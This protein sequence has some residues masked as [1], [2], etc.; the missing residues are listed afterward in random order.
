MVEEA[1]LRGFEYIYQLRTELKKV[2]SMANQALI[3][4]SPQLIRSVLQAGGAA[5]INITNLLGTDYLPSSSAKDDEILYFKSNRIVGSVDL[6]FD[7]DSTPRLISMGISSTSA[8]LDIYDNR[9]GSHGIV[10]LKS[11][12]Q[13]SA[14]EPYLG[15]HLTGTD[16]VTSIGGSIS[17][18]KEQSWTS[19][20]ATRDSRLGFY[21]T[22]NNSN[23]LQMT[24]SSGGALNV[25]NGDVT[26]ANDTLIGTSPGGSG[27]VQIHN[28]DSS[29]QALTVEGVSGQTA[30]IFSV[31]PDGVASTYLSVDASGYTFVADRMGINMGGVAPQTH[32]HI[33]ASGTAGTPATAAETAAIFQYSGSAG[34][35]CAVSIL[36]GATGSSKVYFGDTADDN[37]GSIIY[38]HNTDAMEFYTSVTEGLSIS[39]DQNVSIPSGNLSVSGGNLAV[40]S[41]TL[42]VGSATGTGTIQS[43]STGEQLRLAYDSDSYA[44]FTV[45]SNGSITLANFSGGGANGDMIFKAGGGITFDF[46]TDGGSG[47]ELFKILGATTELIRVQRGGNVGIGTN[48]P[49][50]LL[51]LA[52]NGGGDMNL[53]LNDTTNTQEYT[54]RN[55]KDVAGTFSIYDDT[56]SSHRFAITSSGAVGIGTTGPSALL[57][58]VKTTEQLRLGYDADSYAKFTVTSNGSLT[59]ATYGNVGT[60]GDLFLTAGGGFTIN[61]DSD[62]GSG[63][64]VFSVQG[65]G[66]HLFR[67]KRD[68][69]IGFFGVSPEGQASAYT[70]TNVTPDRSY[71]ANS[72]TLDEVADTLG[73]LVS[74]LQSYGLLG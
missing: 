10:L 24:I 27:F 34:Q 51:E 40:S 16:S 32:L 67:I 5:P 20:A 45:S 73:T 61:F 6:T 23:T 68:G 13:G 22:L 72:T 71:D 30:D 64:E 50:S 7:D 12:A 65:A 70:I 66:S 52:G 43:L 54:L 18:L 4:S 44:S 31:A 55:G 3:K 59:I 39:T 35:D 37:R 53:S 21:T 69:Q 25:P 38:D 49:G 60:S 62:G 26:I 11:T 42:C 33:L 29:K 74:D 56:A 14:D 28:D 57:H 63:G 41:G 58:V 8:Q 17:V 15:F 9:T 36:A 2:R 48:N 19:S 46:D 47:G 1:H